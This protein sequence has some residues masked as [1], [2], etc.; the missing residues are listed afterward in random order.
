MHSAIQ[1]I[2]LMA[3]PNMTVAEP[4]ALSHS[5]NVQPVQPCPAWLDDWAG[6]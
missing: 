5:A 1:P 4:N 2:S 3:E 6:G